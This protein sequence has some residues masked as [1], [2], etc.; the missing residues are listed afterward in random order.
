MRLCTRSALFLILISGFSGGVVAQ[1]AQP[2]AA[3]QAEAGQPAQAAPG[4]PWVVH[5][6]ISQGALDCRAS[7]SLFLKNT[8]QHIMSVAVRIPPDT[9]K[10]VLLMQ[11]PLG[12]YLPAGVSLQI[13]K[14]EAKTLPIE[15]CD[16]A[17]C[18]AEYAITDAEIGAMLKGAALTITLQSASKEP[19]TLTVPATGFPAAYAKI[20]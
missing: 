14:D 8:G 17:G 12:I 20:K 9:K 18:L 6:P 3:P 5:C 10:P 15:N 11:L 4:E 19:V 2:K 7:Q 13:G 1:T 16:Q